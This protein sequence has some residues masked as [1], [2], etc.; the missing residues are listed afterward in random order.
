MQVA[1]PNLLYETKTKP[2]KQHK[3][4]IKRPKNPRK[5]KIKMILCS[6]SLFFF[7]YIYMFLQ[8]YETFKQLNYARTLLSYKEEMQNMGIVYVNR[9]SLDQIERSYNESKKNAEYRG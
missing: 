6:K 3:Q 2:N 4:K 9:V 8:N 5:P 1:T 7:L